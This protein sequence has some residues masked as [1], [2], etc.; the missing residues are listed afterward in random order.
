MLCGT[1]DAMPSIFDNVI[2]KENDHTNLLRNLMDRNAK[3][4]A[5]ILSALTREEVSETEAAKF[6]YRT[7]QSFTGPD[8][9]EIPDIVIEGEQLRCL[10]EAKIDPS[11]YL[12]PRQRE[13][14][15]HCFSED[16]EKKH[17]CFLVPRD[18]VHSGDVSE[19]ERL[20][21]SKNVKVHR[22]DWQDLISKIAESNSK[23]TT[24]ELLK[25]I[26]DFWKWRFE[27]NHM[28]Q[29]ER[30][31]IRTWSGEK[32]TAIRKLEKTL[33]Q[34]KKL[35][36]ARGRATELETDVTA[37]GFYIK[38]DLSYLLW[39]GIWDKAP[40]PLSYGYEL[41]GGEWIRPSVR[42]R[43]GTTA[44]NYH[45]WTLPEDAWD[46]PERVYSTVESFLNQ[47]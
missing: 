43:G 8:G 11:L 4:A 25:E 23:D 27:I 9:R 3:I 13:G 16:R 20:L 18:W 39:I 14:Y 2:T 45:L 30:E 33:D 35:F 12:T 15:A 10:I 24:S 34:A 44:S 19:V 37:Y 21:L 17:L 41:S 29:E 6:S 40:T 31:V 7:Q 36:D 22:C 42:P 46:Q 32:Y 47:Y 5:L 1:N 26:L 28:T 38:R